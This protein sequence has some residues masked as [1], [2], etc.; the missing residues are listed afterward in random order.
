[1]PCPPPKIYFWDYPSPKIDPMHMYGF[2]QESSGADV[3]NNISTFVNYFVDKI[4]ALKCQILALKKGSKQAISR[5]INFRRIIYFR[6][7][8]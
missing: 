3:L 4:L 8:I 2:D 5:S 1:M 7:I 6:S